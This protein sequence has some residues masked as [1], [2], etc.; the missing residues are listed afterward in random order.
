MAT[1]ATA[2]TSSARRVRRLRPSKTA[3]SGIGNAPTG[4]PALG[5]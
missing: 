2:P 3:V 5:V 1:T 4:T